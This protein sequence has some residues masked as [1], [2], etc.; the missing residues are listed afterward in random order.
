MCDVCFC[1]VPPFCWS[2][3]VAAA[4]WSCTFKTR[5]PCSPS[6]CRRKPRWRRT[7]ATT[8]GPAEAL[9]S[10]P[11]PTTPSRG[12]TA[13]PAHPLPLMPRHRQPLVRPLVP[14]VMTPLLLRLLARPLPTATRQRTNRTPSCRRH[15][16]PRTRRSHPRRLAPATA[17]PRCPLSP[18]PPSSHRRPRPRHNPPPA[19]T[20]C[21]PAP[22]HRHSPCKRHR[23]RHPPPPQPPPPRRRLRHSPRSTRRRRR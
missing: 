10:A 22:R 7:R 8:C 4:A 6:S 21:L 20:P 3:A 16:H 15:R 17:S 5:S 12:Q 14:V 9:T 13:L 1:G 2:V 23:P 19:H 11:T 18:C